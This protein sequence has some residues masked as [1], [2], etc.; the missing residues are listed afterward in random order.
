MYCRGRINIFHTNC[1]GHI[2]RRKSL[3]K[4]VIEEV[5]GRRERIRKRL[6]YNTATR[7][8]WKFKEEKLDHA[9]WTHH[10]THC[11]L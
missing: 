5:T 8:Y 9:L 6:L 3:L 7:G 2:L 4:H 10:K 11:V 1:I